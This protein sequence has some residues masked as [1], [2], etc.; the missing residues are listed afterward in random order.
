MLLEIIIAFVD[1]CKMHFFRCVFKDGSGSMINNGLR[2]GSVNIYSRR[3]RVKHAAI[4]FLKGQRNA[5]IFILKI[6]FLKIVMNSTDE[7]FVIAVSTGD[8]KNQVHLFELGIAPSL[9]LSGK[10]DLNVSHFPGIYLQSQTNS[11]A[12]GKFPY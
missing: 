4:G 10:L 6:Q 8:P 11:I 7:R 1:F 5:E 9:G 12:Q 3:R 2:V